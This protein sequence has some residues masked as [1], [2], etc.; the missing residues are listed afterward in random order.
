MRRIFYTLCA[1][2]VAMLLA[3]SMVGCGGTGNN[4]NATV[5]AADFVT[6]S[7]LVLED[8][9][10]VHEI[11]TKAVGAAFKEGQISEAKLRDIVEGLE[12]FD[13]AWLAASHALLDYRIS[14]DAG[15]APGRA[16]LDTAWAAL[17]DNKAM[18][19]KLAEGIPALSSVSALLH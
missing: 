19:A 13:K 2:A 3:V 11:G 16:A 17:L 8:L 4:Q 6:Q 14:L 5:S 12:A 1:L 10:S 7:K 18:L 15:K 9:E